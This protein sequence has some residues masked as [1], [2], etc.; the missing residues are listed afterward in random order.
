MPGVGEEFFDRAFSILHNLPHYSKVEELFHKGNFD[1]F[2]TRPLLALALLY[3]ER[4]LLYGEY[5]DFPKAIQNVLIALNVR[6][7][8]LQKFG[9]AMSFSIRYTYLRLSN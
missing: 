4:G 7:Y 1:S 5:N 3:Q 6:K 2:P 9:K 8:F